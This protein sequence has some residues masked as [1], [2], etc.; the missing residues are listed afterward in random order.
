M[1]TFPKYRLRDRLMVVWCSNHRSDGPPR[2]QGCTFRGVTH[3][4]DEL[5]VFTRRRALGMGI[6]E[7]CHRLDS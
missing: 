7:S 3:P 1:P 4:P 5:G 2:Q 6:S